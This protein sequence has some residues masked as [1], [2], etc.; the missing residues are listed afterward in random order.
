MISKKNINME[1]KSAQKIKGEN[2]IS[3]LDPMHKT[4]FQNNTHTEES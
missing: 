4:M 2:V 3:N 1:P